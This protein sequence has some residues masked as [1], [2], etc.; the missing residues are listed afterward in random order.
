MNNK[1]ALLKKE[2]VLKLIPV[3][4]ATW[5]RLI[6]EN[7]ELKPVKL[8]RGSFWKKTVIENFINGLGDEQV[9]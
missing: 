9:S 8:G 7:P 3:S 2:D 5:Y 4:T 6:K 1:N